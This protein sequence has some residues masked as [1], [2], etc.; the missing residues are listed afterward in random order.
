M[1]PEPEGSDDRQTPGLCHVDSEAAKVYL[2]AL[3]DAEIFPSARWEET[4]TIGDI[5]AKVGA[6]VAPDYD[7]SD[8]CDFCD[9]VK[10]NFTGRLAALKKE[11]EKRL[12][13]MCLDCYKAGGSNAEE[14]RYE[15][16]K[17]GVQANV[18]AGRAGGLGIDGL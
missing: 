1:S 4:S 15:H 6:F 14:C 17:V 11:H 18:A 2:G 16:A 7:D 8:K 9:E 5:V 12:W 3:G 10:V 13:G